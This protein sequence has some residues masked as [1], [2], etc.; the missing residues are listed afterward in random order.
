MIWSG[1]IGPVRECHVWTNRPIWPQAIGRPPGSDPVPDYLDWDLWLGVAPWRPYV[2]AHPDT[3]RPEFSASYR[4][5]CYLP[6]VWRG[7]W[8]FGCGALGD[9]G[10]HA[11]D[12]ANWALKLCPPTSVETV[13]QEGLNEETGPTQS[14]LRYA[15]PARGDM[16]ALSLYWYDGGARPAVPEGVPEDQV[17][18]SNGCLFLGD[19]GQVL[20]GTYGDHPRLV[21]FELMED[22]TP[23]TPY[24]PRIDLGDDRHSR[25]WLR[26]CKGGPP[27]CSNFAYAGPLSEIVLLGNV[28]LRAGTAD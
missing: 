16:P 7:W 3:D 28:A 21:P 9:M 15:F 14:V 27:A 5:L 24:L 10:C 26:A 12:P 22:Y 1:A 4:G 8:D 11:M 17:S 19:D 2:K 25:D 13:M 18:G 20:C 6:K 23:P